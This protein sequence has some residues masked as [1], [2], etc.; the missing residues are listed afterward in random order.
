MWQALRAV[1][2]VNAS[3]MGDFIRVYHNVDVSVAVQTPSGL[4]V[5]IVRDADA[6]GLADIAAAVKDLAAKVGGPAG[7]L[8]WQHCWDTLGSSLHTKGVP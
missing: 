6:L 8:P 4:M 1:P 7:I 5:P 3:W 2:D